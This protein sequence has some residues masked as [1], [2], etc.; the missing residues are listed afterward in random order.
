MSNADPHLV[1]FMVRFSFVEVKYPQTIH[2]ERKTAACGMQNAGGLVKYRRSPLLH[3]Q[4]EGGEAVLE[5]LI[6]FIQ[7]VIASLVA[8][9]ISKWLDGKIGE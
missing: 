5:L 2:G 3:W 6:S 9:I 7:S 4:Q 8:N 1:P